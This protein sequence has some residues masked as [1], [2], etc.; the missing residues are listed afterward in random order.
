MY[1]ESLKKCTGIKCLTSNCKGCTSKN[2]CIVCDDFYVLLDGQ[3]KG[4][5]KLCPPA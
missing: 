2:K 3:C 1:D 5:G 4:I